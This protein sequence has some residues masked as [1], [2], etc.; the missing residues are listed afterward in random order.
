MPSK[1]ET[2]VDHTWLPSQMVSDA[3]PRAVRPFID[4]TGKP[5]GRWW[6]PGFPST[7]GAM[8]KRSFDT[9]VR[10]HVAKDVTDAK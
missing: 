3:A 7:G 10:R 6:Y 4:A 1:S 9:W 8:S 5:W 2:A